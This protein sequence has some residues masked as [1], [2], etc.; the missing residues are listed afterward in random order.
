VF[1]LCVSN[2]AINFNRES[3]VFS[4]LDPNSDVYNPV[5]LDK[6]A[7]FG[8]IDVHDESSYCLITLVRVKEEAG[9]PSYQVVGM[10]AVPLTITSDSVMNGVFEVPMIDLPVNQTFFSEFN[11]ITAWQFQHRVHKDKKA[12]LTQTTVMYRQSAHELSV[13]LPLIPRHCSPLPPSL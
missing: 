4:E 11:N 2:E 6:Q 10:N 5:F 9:R 13:G 8:N 12:S 1:V 3:A 7:T